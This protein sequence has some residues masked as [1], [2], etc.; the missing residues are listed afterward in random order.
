[1]NLP[2]DL[3]V[4]AATIVRCSPLATSSSWLVATP[5]TEANGDWRITTGRR[6]RLATG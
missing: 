2:F 5:T 6:Q 4:N 3:S 1:L